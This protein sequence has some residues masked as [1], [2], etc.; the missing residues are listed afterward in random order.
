VSVFLIGNVLFR[1]TLGIGRG[2][3]RLAAAV[4]AP[5]TIALGT[6][7]SAFAQLAA[8][9]ALLLAMLVIERPGSR[10]SGGTGS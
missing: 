6:E 5:A 9:A 2:S 10:V 8:L 7:L 4:L 3:M 1:R